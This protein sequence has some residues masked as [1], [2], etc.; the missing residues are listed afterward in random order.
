MSTSI[1]LVTCA[2]VSS[3][4]RMCSAMPRRIAVTGSS[5]SPGWASAG[6]RGA[7]A[8]AGGGGGCGGGLRGGRR[9]LCGRSRSGSGCRGGRY[10][11]R[12]LAAALDEGEDVLLRHAAA[13]AG[14]VHLAGV[15]AVLGR[16]ARD[17][18]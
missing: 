15:H 11:S 7:A 4:R 14:A 10:G 2:A 3:E 18:R 6:A 16:D 1:A 9:L 12:A 5:C 13:A 8:G 17:H